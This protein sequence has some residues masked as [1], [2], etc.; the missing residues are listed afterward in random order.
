M[1]LI[2]TAGVT[3]STLLDLVKEWNERCDICLWH[4]KP[5]A[6]PVVAGF[7]LAHNFN[8]TVAMDLKHFKKIYLLHMISHATRFTATAIMYSKQKKLL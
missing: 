6:K 8:D 7:S 4:K 1:D 2:K 3:D 5:K